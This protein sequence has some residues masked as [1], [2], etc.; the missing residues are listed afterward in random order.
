MLILMKCRHWPRLWHTNVL[1]LMFPL[2]ELKE[3]S[4]SIPQNTQYVIKY[5]AKGPSKKYVH[6]IN[7]ILQ[8]LG[9]WF[10][11][12]VS[13]FLNLIK[14]RKHSCPGSLIS[15]F[16]ENH[17]PWLASHSDLLYRP[18]IISSRPNFC[19]VSSLTDLS[20]NVSSFPADRRSSIRSLTA[21]ERNFS[22]R[23]IFWSEKSN[24]L[25]ILSCS[26][27]WQEYLKMLWM[28]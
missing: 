14:L 2:V 17:S 5:I 24:N 10:I 6:A 26:H 4:R 23:K 22:V 20:I 3:A 27:P 19:Q 11:A 8:I 16:D 15:L 28:Y 7:S 12:E 25:L 1:W 18:T 9:W 21:C 13:N